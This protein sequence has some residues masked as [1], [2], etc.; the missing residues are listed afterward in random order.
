MSAGP[1]LIL[2][3]EEEAVGL[4]GEPE[5]TEPEPETRDLRRLTE[6]VHDA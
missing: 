5:T 3:S 1:A 6:E 2:L 4:L